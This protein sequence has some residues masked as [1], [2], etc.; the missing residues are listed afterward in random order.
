MK[1]FNRTFLIFIM[2][3]SCANAVVTDIFSPLKA[4]PKAII[5]NTLSRPVEFYPNNNLTRYIGSFNANVAVGEPL[6]LKGTLMDAFGVPIEGANIRI[7]HTNSAGKYQSLQRD[8]SLYI[9]ENFRGSGTARTDNLGRYGFYTIFPGFFADRAP[10]I[11]V[12]V[13]SPRFK[14][15][16]T[17]LYFEGH[18]RNQNDPQFMSYPKN[19][20]E[21]L[22][23]RVVN[24]DV[25]DPS[26]GKI[27]TFDIIVDIIH[28]YKGF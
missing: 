11:N 25:N 24:A 22:I 12:E 26:K 28:Q 21:M 15:F 3:I 4:T 23:A 18:P 10:H 7:W 16:I 13:S 5:T 19:D 9:D 8:D 6:Y 17:E 14:T 20:R 27:A 2:L 1:L